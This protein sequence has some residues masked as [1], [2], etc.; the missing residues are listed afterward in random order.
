MG[1][2]SKFALCCLLPSDWAVT[3]EE[4]TLPKFHLKLEVDAEKFVLTFCVS[5]ILIMVFSLLCVQVR[6]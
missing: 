3:A 1:A 2:L 6:V 5:A 4:Q